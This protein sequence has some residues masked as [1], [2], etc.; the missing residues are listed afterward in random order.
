MLFSSQVDNKNGS[1]FNLKH[2]PSAP[3]SICSLVF[4]QP[5]F[6]TKIPFNTTCNNVM[7]KLTNFYLF[8]I[9]LTS[10]LKIVIRVHSGAAAKTSSVVS[11]WVKVR[12]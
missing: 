4:I 12:K 11:P 2:H 1:P 5:A 10:F 6:L 9:P 3:T 7:H 8:A